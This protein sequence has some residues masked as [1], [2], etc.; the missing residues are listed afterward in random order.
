MTNSRE[1]NKNSVLSAIDRFEEKQ[2]KKRSTKKRKNNK[3]EEEVVK[4]ILN[5]C[6]NNGWF[7]NRYESKAKYINGN[8]RVSGLKAGTPDL[9]GTCVGGYSAWIEVKAPGR[10]SRSSEDQKKFLLNVIN[11]GGFGVC[12]DSVELLESMHMTWSTLD[13]EMRIDYLKKF[14]ID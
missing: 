4:A 7:V 9:G 1:E 14:L 13:K 5:W 3:P 11:L 12:V 8:W 2:L 6:D 10:V